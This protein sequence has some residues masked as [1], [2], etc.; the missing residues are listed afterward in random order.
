MR[1]N[2]TNILCAAAIAAILILA[3]GLRL[4]D[5]GAPQLWEDDYLSLDRASMDLGRMFQVQKYQ[6]PADT[7]F[8]FAPPLSYA[9]VHLALGLSPTAAAARAPSLLAGILTV[10]GFFLLGKTLF[11]RKTGL[12]AAL[13]CALSLFHI[14]F[15]RAVKF[16]A[17]FLCFFVFSS[18]FLLAALSSGK[19]RLFA[20][21]A[22]TAAAMLYSGYQGVPVFAAQAAYAVLALAASRKTLNAAALKKRYLA[23]FL[24]LAAA[25]AAFSPFL[26]GVFFLNTFLQNPGVDILQG[27]TPGFFVAVAA[28]QLHFVYETPPAYI[29]LTAALTL[30]G[31]L[32]CPPEK[33]LRSLAFLALIAGLPALAVITSQSHTRLMLSPRHL[34]S[35][36]PAL[37]LLPAFGLSFLLDR[38]AART[39]DRR[40][41]LRALAAG[42]A[43]LAV[44]LTLFW[45]SISRLDGYYE[46]TISQD[47]EFFRWLALRKNNIQGLDFTGY[48]RNIKR[49]AASWHLSG[50]Y[51]PAGTWAAPAYRRIYLVD[52]YNTGTTPGPMP[53][54]P[55]TAFNVA[56]FNTRVAAMGLAS[57]APL[58]LFP[59]RDG[60]FSYNAALTGLD[61]YQDAFSADNMTLDNELGMLRPARYSRQAEVVYAFTAPDGQAPTRIDAA[62]TAKLYKRHP[63]LASDSAMEILAGPDGKTF[64]PVGLIDGPDF[65]NG[66]SGGEEEPCA[67]FEEIGFYQSCRVI[68]KTVDL[69]RHIGKDGR[70][71]VKI[72]ITPGVKEGFLNL[73]GFRLDAAAFPA[74]DAPASWPLALAAKN[75]LANNL[76]HPWREHETILGPGVFGFAGQGL[77]PGISMDQL[78]PAGAL[79][80]FL[81]AH[82]KASPVYELRAPNGEAA[83]TLFDPSLAD[84]GV[85]LG[86]S[87]PEAKAILAGKPPLAVKSLR[88]AGAFKAPIILAGDK[89][90][91][92]P[93]AA[94]AGSTL[95]LN[96]R[97]AGRL[98]F[99]PDFTKEGFSTASMANSANIVSGRH[100]DYDG[101]VCCAPGTSCFFTYAFVSAYP[102]TKLR[103]RV[104]PRVYGDA[105][106]PRSCK[107]SYSTDGQNFVP[108][109]ELA[110]DGSNDWS[111]MFLNRFHT[112]NFDRPAS[113]VVARFDLSADFQAQFWSPVRPVDRM[114]LEADLDASLFDPISIATPACDI[115]LDR[116]EGN[117]F[118]LFLNPLATPLS[119][120]TYSR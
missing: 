78:S 55:V 80:A 68:K 115:R 105:K 100:P 53:G 59:G 4:W 119:E 89:R 84:P 14:D 95:I 10:L 87:S 12:F 39:P 67:F 73:G 104:Y 9:L 110:G 29:W 118:Q 72:V 92:I 35:L 116:P 42:F 49:F 93:V 22:L 6:G 109:D 40:P 60:A 13:F 45:P 51:E 17:L 32:A 111:P 83:L 70:L 98:S 120:K 94:P 11:S 99:S 61:F 85:R 25:A 24:A 54:A 7:I 82:P 21:Y 91:E 69:S 34:I 102:I 75:L 30:T 26:E 86:P 33:K 97:G 107:V 106:E 58:A 117:D 76:V 16:Y 79:D 81:A 27:L 50:L 48:K 90:M 57:R 36:F 62:I 37:L 113:M 74:G 112:V 43:G 96:A 103:L 1:K 28:K 41:A 46:R 64:E 15:S 71:F 19:A 77:P 88:L 63:T 114:Y 3:V 56:I 23:L 47:R 31:I 5:I 8:D 44:C 18:Y 52:N 65:L 101:V 66:S 38:A 108:L 2:T 20:A